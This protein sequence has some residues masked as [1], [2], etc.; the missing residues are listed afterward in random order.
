MEFELRYSLISR[1]P[2]KINTVFPLSAPRPFL[3]RM[4]AFCPAETANECHGPGG[5][6]A[7]SGCR[8]RLGERTIEMKNTSVE[9][10]TIAGPEGMSQREE[11]NTPAT[12]QAIPMISEYHVNV[13]RLWVSW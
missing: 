7:R 12:E 9:S 3:R 1:Q 10:S 6:L 13:E 11:S 2:H 8:E 5:Q 4:E